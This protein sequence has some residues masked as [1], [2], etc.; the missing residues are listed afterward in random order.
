MSKPE[1][2]ELRHMAKWGANHIAS[3]DIDPVYP[4]LRELYRA[5]R[6]SPEQQMWQTFL[7]MAFY[8]LPS[9]MAVYRMYPEPT[10]APKNILG[11][12]CAFERRG[13]RGGKVVDHIRDGV[14]RIW[15]HTSANS[16]LEAATFG[17]G[18]DPE[19]N[20]ELFWKWSQTIYGNGPW[21]AFKWAEI[22]KK[23]HGLQL[24]APDMRMKSSADKSAQNRPRTCLCWLYGVPTDTPLAELNR[25]AVDLKWRLEELGCVAEDWEELETLLCDYY[26]YREGKY[27]T[28]HDI[29]EMGEAIRKSGFLHPSDAAALYEA[30]ERG[31]PPTFL[32][33]G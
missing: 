17:W 18:S 2:K 29:I 14:D 5:R 4:V 31:L 24:A 21:A 8:H 16:G 32:K 15:F 27:D 12:P 28:G 22:L 10:V 23:C 6:M 11:L 25:L 19:Q 20:Y 7:Y 33:G 30:R 26:K 13:F 3:G 9:G 1:D